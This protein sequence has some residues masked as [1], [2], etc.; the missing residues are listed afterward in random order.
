VCAGAIVQAGPDLAV[1]YHLT[2]V[3]VNSEVHLCEQKSLN[4]VCI[5]LL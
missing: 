2:F 5:P 4:C 1:R 3:L